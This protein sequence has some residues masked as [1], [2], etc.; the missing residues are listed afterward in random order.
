MRNCI[1]TI[2]KWHNALGQHAILP[3]RGAGIFLPASQSETIPRA[4]GHCVSGC[5]RPRKSGPINEQ[6]PW[7]ALPGIGSCFCG[8]QTLHEQALVARAAVPVSLDLPPAV[9]SLPCGAAGNKP[10]PSAT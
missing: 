10:A 1:D 2:I 4:W 7:A 3:T 9:L 8:R 5:K 6:T